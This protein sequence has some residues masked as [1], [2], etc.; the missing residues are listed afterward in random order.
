MKKQDILILIENDII[1]TRLISILNDIGVDLSSYSLYIDQLI[2]K[3]IGLKKQ[4]RT[5]E[6]YEKYFELLKLGK[7]I[8]PNNVAELKQLALKIYR[9]LVGYV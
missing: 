7:S 5:D 1:N 4:L 3:S 6:L 2:F 8:H 9:F